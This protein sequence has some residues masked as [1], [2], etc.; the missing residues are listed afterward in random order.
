[1]SALGPARYSRVAHWRGRQR[2]ERFFPALR[3]P[4]APAGTRVDPPETPEHQIAPSASR[5]IP[6]PS[7]SA[8]T[9]RFERLPS[10]AMSNAVSRLAQDS[11]TTSVEYALTRRGWSK[12]PES[13]VT[14]RIPGWPANE[15]PGSHGRGR[16]RRSSS[17][18][19]TSGAGRRAARPAGWGKRKTIN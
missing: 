8:Q 12:D 6:S 4:R 2:R 18:G 13:T 3:R 19:A 9:R 5:Q 1:V 17:R 10:S 14:A 7:T 16:G 11:A 15:A